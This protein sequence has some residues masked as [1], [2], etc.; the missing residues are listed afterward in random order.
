MSY[1]STSQVSNFLQRVLNAY[2]DAE[3]A[4]IVA[5]VQVWIDKRLNSTFDQVA[6]STRYYDGGG[7]SLDI[8][9][10]T[11]ITEVKTINDDSSSSYTYT[12]G[13]EY[14]SEPQNETVKRELRKRLTPFP[15]GI[16]RVAV[17]A[18][19]SEYDGGVPADIQILA[20]RL[21]AGIINSGKSVA[22]GN[23]SSESLE[24]HSIS[25]N[26]DLTKLDGLAENDPTVK[27]ILESRKEFYVDNYDRS[28]R[29]SYED[30][31]GLMI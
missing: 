26:T 14:I 15:R 8:D 28:E 10:C 9:P 11:D 1:T 3:L 30:D 19:F 12:V 24:G 2:E 7:R 27:S 22:S 23:V 21:V 20:T 16:Q 29:S 31:G 13:T 5:A 4:I 18:K 6:E 17:T 25:F